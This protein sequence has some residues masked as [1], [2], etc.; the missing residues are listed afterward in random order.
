SV[1]GSLM[2][3]SRSGERRW[4]ARVFVFLIRR[5]AVLPARWERACWPAMETRLR[6]VIGHRGA[7]GYWP[8]NTLAS[9]AGAHAMG[10][11]L[12]EVDVVASRD[13]EAVV[14]H[15]VRLGATT[16]VAARFPGRERADGG[17][18]AV[19]FDWAELRTLRVGE[20]VDEAT[21]RPVFPGRVLRGAGEAGLCRLGELLEFLAVL[22][23]EGGREVGLVL[24]IKAPA[25]HRARGRD[26]EPV[27]RGLLAG[28][29]MP[30]V[31]ETFDP[32]ELRR[33]RS[34][35]AGCPSVE[36]WQL[37]G[38]N[39]WGE[40]E[41]DYEAMRTA[42]GLREIA[43]VASGV[44]VNLARATPEFVGAARAGGLAVCAYTARVEVDGA[45]LR[46][47]LL[48]SGLDG[49]FTDQPDVVAG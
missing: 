1:E 44:A 40:A 25:W 34:A 29:R 38:E 13:G 39:A 18:Y 31:V 24:E 43:T 11:D 10:A 36:W 5:A 16:D 47:R 15:D 41:C 49:V 27:V 42:R 23:R 20:R 48:A 7:C 46:E 21:G 2:A 17:F 37:L 3:V 19:D 26:L 22:N 35:W 32:A 45:G 4:R 9:V 33:W 14:T 12:I 30:V 8:E 6:W 28:A